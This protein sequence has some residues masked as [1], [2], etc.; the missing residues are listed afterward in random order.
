MLRGAIL[1]ELIRV[2]QQI[3]ALT[4][5]FDDI[6]EAALLTSTDDEHD[7]EG[8]TIAFE[9]A[10][11]TSLLRTAKADREALRTTMDSLDDE[12]YGVCEHCRGFIGVERLLALP[13][14][15]RCVSCAH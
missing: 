15:T 3:A 8:A 9:R 12:G 6:V 11:V 2:D 7:P 5:S 4:R 14:A 13:A 10:Q 1:D